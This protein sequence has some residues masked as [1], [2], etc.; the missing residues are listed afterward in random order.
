MNSK[1]MKPQA[2]VFQDCFFIYL[3]ILLPNFLFIS[4][5]LLKILSLTAVP[6]TRTGI[7]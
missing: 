5:K 3:S 1:L 6:K 4:S 7:F 2:S